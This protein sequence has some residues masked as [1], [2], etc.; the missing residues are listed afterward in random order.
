YDV[1]REA[2]AVEQSSP[3]ARSLAEPN[4]ASKEW[5]YR[6]YDHLVGS[7]TVRRP[8]FDAAVVRLRPSLRGI[9][10]SLQGPRLGELDPRRA[11][12]Q[13]VLG[14]ALNVACTGGEPLAL[15]DC[16]NFGN[17]AKPEIGWE[18]AEAIDAIAE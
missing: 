6:Q 9:A 16:L 18:L 15:T 1:E 10:V 3:R 14:A 17:P 8:G 13:A 7:R 5:I 11:G 4:V 12:L 2:Q